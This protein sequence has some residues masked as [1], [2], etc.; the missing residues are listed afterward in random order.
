[1]KAS[2]AVA[3][4]VFAAALAACGK[5]ES[6]A[7]EPAVEAQGA[8][9]APAGGTPERSSN[10]NPDTPADQFV[11]MVST[12]DCL[13]LY[14]VLAPN[15]GRP[16]AV[17]QFAAMEDPKFRNLDGFART[18]AIKAAEGAFETAVAPMKGKTLFTYT[19]TS[20]D[21]YREYNME[22]KAFFDSTR[23]TWGS[24][25]PLGASEGNTQLSLT[26]GDGHCILQLVNTENWKGQFKVEDEGQA[27][28]ADAARQ[29]GNG[30]VRFY[31]RA[32]EADAGTLDWPRVKAEV[33]RIEL[34][35]KDGNFLARAQPTI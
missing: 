32:V 9:E 14:T 7:A 34:V 8:A 17:A 3:T 16:R 13:G 28:A 31:L 18:D 35:D 24:S 11:A 23:L 12:E 2:G 19:S 20:N 30:H 4:I 27:R 1:M 6:P 25:D 5:S 10:P 26:K 29:A 15:D 22:Q 21:D 33:V